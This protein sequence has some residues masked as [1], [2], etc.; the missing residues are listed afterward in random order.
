MGTNKT[1]TTSQSCLRINYPSWPGPRNH[2]SAT[3]PLNQQPPSWT[4]ER[5]GTT[6]RAPLTYTGL[7][8]E[9]YRSD[10]SLLAKPGN[11]HR[12]PLHWSGRCSSLVRPIQARK[13]QILQTGQPNSILTQT[14]NN[15]NTG[16]QR[17]QSDVHPTQKTHRASTS[18]KPVSYTGQ[19]C[20]AGP[21]GGEQH[22]WVNSPKSNS[23]SPK[24][25]N[26]FVQDFGIVG[27]PHGYSMS[28]RNVVP[29]LTSNKRRGLSLNGRC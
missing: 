15:S 9:Q 20:Q 27:T 14:R 4:R 5:S 26:E 12:R 25:L 1:N 28:V 7:A 11:F 13:P 2:W 16:Q 17:T 18:V 19:T 10:W 8:G 3:D 23:R 6:T 21:L 24:S 22:P 29:T